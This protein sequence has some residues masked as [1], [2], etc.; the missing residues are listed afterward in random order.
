LAM[1]SLIKASCSPRLMPLRLTRGLMRAKRNNEIR[2]RSSW[3]IWMP[4]KTNTG[5]SGRT[6]RRKASVGWLGPGNDR[7]VGRRMRGDKYP[8]GDKTLDLGRGKTVEAALDEVAVIPVLLAL[9]TFALWPSNSG[10]L[11]PEARKDDRDR[12]E[13]AAPIASRSAGMDCPAVGTAPALDPHLLGE[14]IEVAG[15]KSMAPETRSAAPRTSP[16]SK[17]G[18]LLPLAYNFRHTD[19]HG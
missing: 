13:K 9:P 3:S 11:C 12:N 17:P 1:M 14:S 10:K 8:L 15:N 16:R 6:C 18:V 7:T 4:P 2:L 19:R 5:A